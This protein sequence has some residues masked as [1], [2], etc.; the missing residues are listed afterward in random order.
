MGCSPTWWTVWIERA[1]CET[2]DKA[3]LHEFQDAVMKRRAGGARCKALP[4]PS[5][6]HDARVCIRTVARAAVGPCTSSWWSHDSPC[7]RALSPT[8][9]HT[10][11]ASCWS[12][13]VTST[14]LP[15]CRPKCSVMALSARRT[16]TH[17]VMRLNSCILPPSGQQCSCV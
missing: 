9:S 14:P 5:C 15:G 12:G 7:P 1:Q 13:F 10:L 17:S 4:Q 6:P 11:S 8:E 16:H 3:L 2:Q